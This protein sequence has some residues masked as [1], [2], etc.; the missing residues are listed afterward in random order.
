MNIFGYVNLNDFN[1]VALFTLVAYL[2]SFFN[3]NNVIILLSAILVTNALGNTQ[4]M[5]IEG[6]C[7]KKGKLYEGMKG[8]DPKE[9]EDYM[10]DYPEPENDPDE[11]E[12]EK[13]PEMVT[14]T[15]EMN[16]EGFKE[17]AA[18]SS[19][20][21]KGI[22]KRRTLEEQ[23][24]NLDKIIGKDGIDAMTADTQK[25]IKRQGKLAESMKAM[26]PLLKNAESL[27]QGF[28]V[29]QLEGMQN[30]LKSLKE[31]K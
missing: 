15:S 3:K 27:L 21:G 11:D 12:E 20:G 30:T 17:D 13:E 18:S 9:E 6:M 2:T 24:S 4:F 19:Y 8:M 25:L 14:E 1:S 16:T 7:N 28:D 5:V 23:Y 31:K 29:G 10:D 26:G 22:N